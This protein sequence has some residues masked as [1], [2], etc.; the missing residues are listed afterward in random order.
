MDHADAIRS[1]AAERY[2]LGEIVGPPRDEFEEHFMGCL[3][4]ARDIRAGA[5][6]IGNAQEVL[7]HEVL[8]ATPA[9]TRIAPPRQTWLAALFRPA[10]MA[11]ALVVLLGIVGYQQIVV[12]PHLRSALSA[13]NTPA[14]I[15]SFSLL[16]GSS[17]GEAAV[18]VIVRPDQPFTLYVDVPPQPPF[19]MYTFDVETTEGASKFSLPVSGED[20]RKTVLV[21]VPAGQLLPGDY[22]VAIRGID[23][24]GSPS[25]SEVGKVRFSLKYAQ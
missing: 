10:V 2:L 12:V 16:A 17:R 13:A 3:E 19:P 25:S 14:E 11:P 24:N 5:V 18:P 15:P 6:F 4:C 8:P 1:K 20:A 7:R 22:V 21:L 23:G 9:M